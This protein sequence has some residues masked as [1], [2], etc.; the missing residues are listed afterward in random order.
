MILEYLNT[1]ITFCRSVLDCA[2]H[3]YHIII[4]LLYRPFSDGVGL[5]LHNIISS[6]ML[7]K[8]IGAILL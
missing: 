8:S 2:T 1:K 3:F 6:G 5:L 4:S 7:V